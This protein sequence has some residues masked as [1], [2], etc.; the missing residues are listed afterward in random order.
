MSKLPGLTSTDKKN[1]GKHISDCS[2]HCSHM[3]NCVA[4]LWHK[5]DHHCHV[6]LG[7]PTSPAVLAAALEKSVGY[8]ACF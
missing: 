7:A 4:I 1:V 6:L 2:A 5:I 3:T 8:D